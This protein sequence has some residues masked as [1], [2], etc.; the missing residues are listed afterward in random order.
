[1]NIR[2]EVIPT[3][4]S[5]LVRDLCNELMGYQKQKAYIHPEFFD[6]MCFE[7]RMLPSIGSAK[8]NYIVTANAGNDRI[9]YAYSNISSKTIYGGGFATLSCDS[10]FDFSS[11]DGENV[12]CLSQFYIRESHRSLGIGSTLFQMSMDWMRTFDTIDDI[13][14]FVSNGNNN[15]LQFYLNKGFHTSHTIL[16]G[17]IT[18]LRN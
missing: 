1:M 4:Q 8:D 3:E 5:F 2:Y 9:G 18:V 16:D 14:I 12:G 10:F 13:F 11:V 17:F 15:A 7:S 6:T